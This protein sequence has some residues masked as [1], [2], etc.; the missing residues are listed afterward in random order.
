M[1]VVIAIYDRLGRRVKTLAEGE[2]KPGKHHMEWDGTADDGRRV[3]PGSYF[4]RVDILGVGP[5]AHFKIELE[6][7]HAP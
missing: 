6:P 1:K 5:I 7:E 3:L 2:R 4:F